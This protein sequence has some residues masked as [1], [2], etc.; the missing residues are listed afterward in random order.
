[1]T[2]LR[3]IGAL[4]LA[5][6]LVLIG[7]PGCA[8]QPPPPPSPP[9]A[10]QPSANVVSPEPAVVP[11]DQWSKRFPGASDALLSWANRFPHASHR[12]TAWDEEHPG[13]TKELV[14]WALSYP[15]KT[16]AQFADTHPR[17]PFVLEFMHKER[18]TIE[19]FLRW[20]R[21]HEVAAR[22]LFDHSGGFAYSVRRLHPK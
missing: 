17:W 1:M 3:A 10:P 14:I 16:F 19:A 12:V 6:T 15:A 22:A 11:L 5:S 18:P 9:P 21:D 8:T 20:I 2:T 4:S 13:E 7:I